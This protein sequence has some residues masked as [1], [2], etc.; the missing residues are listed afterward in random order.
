MR[1]LV[2]KTRLIYTSVCVAIGIC[3]GVAA[4]G[5]A[6]WAYGLVGIWAFLAVGAFVGG[7]LGL[8]W[9]LSA[10]FWF[11]FFAGDWRVTEIETEIL[12]QKWKM[13]NSGSQRRAAWT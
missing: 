12:G 2:R 7:G 9:R 8:L 11:R 1:V 5:A 13:A 4:A 6:H 10:P 3:V